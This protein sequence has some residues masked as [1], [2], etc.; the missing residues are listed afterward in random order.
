AGGDAGCAAHFH[1]AAASAVGDIERSSGRTFRA[2]A[3]VARRHARLFWL[4]GSAGE[5]HGLRAIAQS[6][7]ALQS[8]WKSDYSAANA[9]SDANDRIIETLRSGKTAPRTGVGFAGK[10]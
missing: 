6:A 9:E 2:V 10:L 7:G 3:S 4:H 1:H 5:L 8:E